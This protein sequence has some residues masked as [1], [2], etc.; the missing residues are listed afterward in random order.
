MSLHP[1]S[2]HK[3]QPIPAQHSPSICEAARRVATIDAP[4]L[5]FP[6]GTRAMAR[7]NALPVSSAEEGAATVLRWPDAKV[8]RGAGKLRITAAVDARVPH[9][10]AVSNAR[11]GERFGM[12]RF[13]SRTDLYLP[14][15]VHVLV[16][17]GD[18]VQGASTIVAQWKAKN[19]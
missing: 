15:E 16:R 1:S 19:R 17:P 2:D 3:Q 18:R 5:A 9:E 12:I 4:N 10:I 13:G 11:T 8:L 14:T 6:E 7:R